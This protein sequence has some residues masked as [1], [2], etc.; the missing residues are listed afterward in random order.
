MHKPGTQLIMDKLW[1]AHA[2]YELGFALGSDNPKTHR[3]G[4]PGWRPG[5]NVRA[6]R[7]RITVTESGPN[8]AERV[9]ELHSDLIKAAGVLGVQCPIREVI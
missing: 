2:A 1:A 7:W 4:F 3:S 9:R 5:F 8:A 6:D